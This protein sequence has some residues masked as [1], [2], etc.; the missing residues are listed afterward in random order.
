MGLRSFFHKIKIG[1]TR[2]GEPSIPY[3]S[4]AKKY[5]DRGENEFVDAVRSRLPDCRIKKNIMIQTPEG[6]A[7]IDCLI[8][9]QNKLFAI[10]IKRWKGRLIEQGGGFIQYKYDRWADE[11]HTKYHRS[12][13]K[14]LGRAIY[15]LR[16][17]IPDP[18][19]LNAVVLFEES[20]SVETECGGVWFDDT[21]EL[22]SYIVHD[23]RASR[24]NAD[25]FFDQCI[26]A[27]YLFCRS[28]GRSLHCIVCD[29]SLCFTT[30]A[31]T[32]DRQHIRSISISHHWSYDEVCITARDGACHSLNMENGS[33]DVI[34]NGS[35]RRYALC[36][37]DYIQ[38]GNERPP[39]PQV[40][41]KP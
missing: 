27:D 20:D 30:P 10:E 17:Q 26:A 13:F 39:V 41:Q 40:L 6:N 31:G 22:V 29:S 7:E 9:Y 18:A 15:L 23:G 28:W 1:F 32:L 19:W 12:P 5:G 2:K 33:V 21:D 36:K 3:T 38:L 4:E 25:A 37:L 34:D 35:K 11:T 24:G 8:L 16:K 14:Q